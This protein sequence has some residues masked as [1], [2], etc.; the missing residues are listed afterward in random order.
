MPS[1][2]DSPELKA[3][4]QQCDALFLPNFCGMRMVFVVVILAQLFAFVLA[5]APLDQPSQLRWQNLGLISLFVQWCA[6]GTA[7]T[8]C[9]VRP[10][11]CRF[12]N[13]QTALLSYLIM[14][15]V[16][17]LISEAAFWLVPRLD[18]DPQQHWH[19]LLRN[20]LIGAIISGPVLRYFYVQHQWRRRIEA[21]SEAR[22][23]A[24]QSRIRP[25]F[26]FNSMNTIASLTRSQPQQAEMAVEN[27]SDLFRASLSDIRQRFTLKQELELCQRYLEIELLRLGEERLQVIWD[28]DRLPG[29]ALIPALTLQPLLENAI[30]H[31]IEL[32]T[33]GGVIEISGRLNNKQIEISLSNPLPRSGADNHQ[34]GNQIAQ[35]NI[36]ERLQAY[37][38]RHADLTVSQQDHS[39]K[40]TL[41]FPYKTHYDEDTDR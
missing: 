17:G 10:W 7:G 8:L 36:R 14:L 23:Q 25:H 40:V 13:T 37:F 39:Y 35:D 12:T 33:E 21:E 4:K 34:K 20:L 6:L 19:Y 26:L 18:F 29:D 41:S 22:L 31:G 5:L 9:L 16:I 32:L 30:Y 15:L 28:T 24:L 1:N 3:S 38:I 11:L 27:L 2:R